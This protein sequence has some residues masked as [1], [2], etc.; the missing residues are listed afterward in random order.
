SCII[1]SNLFSNDSTVQSF[2]GILT[3]IHQ[4]SMKPGRKKH[5]AGIYVLNN[6]F[7]LYCYPLKGKKTWHIGEIVYLPDPLVDADDSEVFIDVQNIS[8]GQKQS[9]LRM[10]WISPDERTITKKSFHS[11]DGD[12]IVTLTLSDGSVWNLTYFDESAIAK[13][14]HKGDKI[15]L[16]IDTHDDTLHSP[17]PD[18]FCAWNDSKIPYNPEWDYEMINLDSKDPLAGTYPERVR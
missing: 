17:F 13:S 6:G 8:T 14:W 9:L 18:Y 11:H 15:R 4:F 12:D 2:E 7:T 5:P 10:G 1:H 16:I 3:D